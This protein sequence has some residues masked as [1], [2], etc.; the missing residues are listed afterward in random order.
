MKNLLK[1]QLPT[2][3]KAGALQYIVALSLLIFFLM[4]MFILQAHYSNLHLD[5]V[6]IQERLHDQLSSAKV[7]VKNNPD[8]LTEEGKSE[9]PLF[10]DSKVALE[11]NNWG[12]YKLVSI[13][14]GFRHHLKK[15][16]FLMGDDIWQENR[17]SLYLADHKRYLS[18]C[19]TSWIGGP[20]YLPALGVRRS[21]VDGVGYYREKVIQGE[22]RKSRTELPVVRPQFKELFEKQWK[23]DFAKDSVLQWEDIEEERV[24]N[25]FNNPNLILHSSEEIVLDQVELSG[26]IKVISDVAIKVLSST[27][28]KNCI[29]IAP[30]VVF[31]RNCKLN[32]QVF[33]RDYVEI[34]QES[35][36]VYPSQVFM[37]GPNVKKELVL[38][39]S[40]KFAGELVVLGKVQKKMPRLKVKKDC[41]V[42]GTVYCDG[43]IEM[44]G[45]V[46]GSVYTNRFILYTRSAM[47]ENHL[48]NNRI[49]IADL[50]ED[51]IGVS[52]FE[53]AHRKDIIEF[54]W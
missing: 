25:A 44:E 2:K 42:E 16:I 48:L 12:V 43:I 27:K 46:A 22:I 33:A 26:R 53:H 31:Q 29:L 14:V 23:L 30:K 35:E 6:L 10:D 1:K 7:L 54:L 51:Y 36:F 40:A 21:Y 52:W 9:L 5:E 8:L 24:I 45:D 38:Q 49:D 11:V 19:G 32:C 37:S 47:Y 4:G 15:E 17:P 20:A 41:K 3:I 50:K 34:G 28:L 39:D 18:L 13:E